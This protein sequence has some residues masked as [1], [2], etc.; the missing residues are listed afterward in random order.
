ML[1]QRARSYNPGPGQ[2][3]SSYLNA[4]R[5][6]RTE[7]NIAYKTA[8]YERWQN[9]DFVVGIEIRNSNNP[10]ICKLCINLAGKYPKDF[11]FTG[12]HPQ[13]R[14]FVVTILASEEE[15]DKLLD[16]ILAD[17][18][19]ADFHS[20]NKITSLPDNLE[21]WIEAN[22][23]KIKD[24]K[25]RNTLPYFIKDNYVDGD[26][27]KGF[28]GERDSGKTESIYREVEKLENQIR[29]NKDFET[30]IV[31]DQEG[32]VILNKKGGS[33]FVA[34]TQS[35]LELCENSI[36]THNHPSGW[37][38]KENAL[39]RIGSS[40]SPQDIKLAIY[41]NLAEMRAV[42][43]HYTFVMK[44]PDTGW[45]INP[46]DFDNEFRRIERGVRR[47][48]D[49]IINNSPRK[50]EDIAVERANILHYHLIW[51][52]FANKFGLTYSKAKTR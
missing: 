41:N 46:N 36:F 24:A 13:C 12:W 27:S 30:A 3:R 32:N 33:N 23:E 8:D 39:G 47:E 5:V 50:H 4:Q 14:C 45:N 43:P 15:I 40:F 1:S 19:T 37:K 6:A 21:N 44:R 22:A 20:E 25:E 11:K 48:M 28:V 17:E 16:K 18:D 52:R 2:Y 38:A 7:T 29:M 34:F 9:L 26:V 31:F 42:T 10:N 49:K 35:E 51:K